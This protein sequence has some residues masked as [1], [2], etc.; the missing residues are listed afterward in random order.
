M[1]HYG[2]ILRGQSVHL[3]W[4]SYNSLGGS[5]TPS[6]AGTCFVYKNNSDTQTAVGVTAH[7]VGVDSLAGINRILVDS[8]QSADF[9]A[10]GNDFHVVVSTASIDGQFVN[11]V[12]GS[13]SVE[14]RYQAGLLRRSLASAGAAQTVTLPT[15]ATTDDWYNGNVVEVVYGPGNGQA[16]QITDYTGSSGVATL[17]RAWSVQPTSASTIHVYVGSL[18]ATLDEQADAVWNEADSELAAVPASNASFRNKVNWVF[19]KSRNKITQT[20]SVQSVRNDGD[21]ADIGAA[22]VSDD[23]TT[24]TRAEFA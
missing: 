18:P 19:A 6:S 7:A 14:N 1:R 5:V 16:R 11:L 15:S 20:S 23:A 3:I 4:H 24:F 17:D 2:D 12:A 9:Y 8:S 10:P 13:F 22:A 21:S